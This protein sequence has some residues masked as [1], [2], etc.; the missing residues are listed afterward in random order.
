MLNQTPTEREKSEQ[1]SIQNNKTHKE[2][3]ELLLFRVVKSF[4]CQL[5]SR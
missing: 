5:K 2:E 1:D 4:V 3:Y